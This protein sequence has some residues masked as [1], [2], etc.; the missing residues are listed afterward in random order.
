MP[1]APGIPDDVIRFTGPLILGFMFNWLLFGVLS[2]QVYYYSLH[3][4]K[5]RKYIKW[6][7]YGLWLWELAQSCVAGRDAFA[8]FGRGWGDPDI[9]LSAQYLWVEIP[10]M[11]GV[12]NMTVQMFYAWRIHVLS[13]SYILP[14]LVTVIALLCGSSGIATGIYVAVDLKSSNVNLQSRADVVTELW[15]ISGAVADIIICSYM[16]TWYWRTR[17]VL[18]FGATEDLITRTIRLSVASGLLTATIA[19][20]AAALFL[21]VQPSYFHMTPDL[22]LGKLYSNSLVAH[23]NHRYRGHEESSLSYS[24]DE[25][26]LARRF[27]HAQTTSVKLTSPHTAST[28]ARRGQT[29]TVTIDTQKEVHDD[30]IPM[31]SFS[32]PAREEDP[33]YGKPA[34]LAD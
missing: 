8:F 29:I 3:F 27:P 28:D 33:E 10:L 13:K 5:D 31:K 12:I 22:I 21:G 1:Y 7:V 18:T 16:L 14:G 2:A 23:L 6:V 19:T 20:I 17:R 11:S 25:D 9:P 34:I 24:V 4:R 30:G 32:E 15:L 26:R